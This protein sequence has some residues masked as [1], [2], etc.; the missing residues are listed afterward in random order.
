VRSPGN[1]SREQLQLELQLFPGVPWDGKAP[2]ALTVARKALLLRQ[3]PPSHEVFVDPEQLEL[4]PI[5]GP[6]GKKASPAPA[7]GAP[8]LMVHKRVKRVPWMED[9]YG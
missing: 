3:K 1:Y 9:Y 2:R 5:E 6:H 7:G 8:L 4:W